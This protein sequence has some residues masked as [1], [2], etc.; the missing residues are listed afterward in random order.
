MTNCH[1]HICFLD[2]MVDQLGPPPLCQVIIWAAA[3]FVD[4]QF[5]KMKNRVIFY[6]ET[7]FFI[8]TVYVTREKH[9]L[10]ISLRRTGTHSIAS[11]S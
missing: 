1:I 9:P 6:L 7:V 2:R 8:F 11:V 10:H 5:V 3:F 4:L